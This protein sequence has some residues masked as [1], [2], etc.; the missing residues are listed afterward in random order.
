[1]VDVIA[2]MKYTR[3]PLK[4][5]TVELQLDSAPEAVIQGTTDRTGR[6]HFS[7]EPAS[8]KVLI[9]G[10]VCFHGRLEGEVLIEFASLTDSGLANDSGAVGGSKG[11]STAYPGMQMRTLNTAHGEVLTDSEGYLV[12]LDDWSE[13]FVRAQAEAEGLSL[14]DEHW[15]VIR[16]LRDYYDTHHFQAQVRDII[17]HFRQVW[18]NEQGSNRYLHALFP[19]GGPQKQGN[20]LAG[21]LRV[22]GEH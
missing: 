3:E 12:N 9:A 15:E 22:K 8:G 7:I 14:R 18:G 1:M 20:R 16:F 11:G 21:L 4:R 13:A 10:K 17:R 19:R 5:T 2:R 6:A